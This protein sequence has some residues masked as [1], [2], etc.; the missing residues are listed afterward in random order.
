MSDNREQLLKMIQKYLAGQAKDTERE[1]L[2]SYFKFFKHEEDLLDKMKNEEQKL[3]G[4]KMLVNILSGLKTENKKINTFFWAPILKVSAAALLLLIC[5]TGV[6]SVFNKKVKPEIAYQNDI[7]PGTNK[8]ILTLNNGQ[9]INLNDAKSG[10]LAKQAGVSISKSSKGQLIYTILNQ[11][12]LNNSVINEMAS[13]NKIETQNGGQYQIILPD[14]TH[15]WLNAASSLT[16]P[17]FFNGTER[18]VSLTGEGYFEVTKDEKRPFKVEINGQTEVRVFGTHFNINA[19][20]DEKTI[21]TTLLEGSVLLKSIHHSALLIPGQQGLVNKINDQIAL[22]ND[23]DLNQVIAW[24]NG[25]FC[26]NSASLDM[27]MKQVE[28]WYDVKVVYNDIVQAEFVAKLP[29]DLPLSELLKLL[30]LTKQV[31]FKLEGKTLTVMK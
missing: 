5:I 22:D 26:Y 19:Y 6:Y 20:N 30:E 27:I 10:E 9:K 14:G 16:Y 3:L 17:T 28:R 1:F 13:I 31:H 23:V 11:P 29:K 18:K 4:E 25:F 7:L 12:N 8:A 2:E 15:V 21:N 24:K